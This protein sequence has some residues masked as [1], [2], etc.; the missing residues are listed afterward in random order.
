MF[1]LVPHHSQTLVEP[2]NSG[3]GGFEINIKTKNLNTTTLGDDTS[4]STS[5]GDSA[6]TGDGEN[7]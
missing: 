5:S 4:L 6:T 1:S 2:L 3:K 7:M